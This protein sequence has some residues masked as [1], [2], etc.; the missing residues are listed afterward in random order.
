MRQFKRIFTFIPILF[1]ILQLSAQ[2]SDRIALELYEGT[3]SILLVWDLPEN[4]DPVEIIIL[5]KTEFQSPFLKLDTVTPTSTRYCD[6][7]IKQDQR[8]FYK[9][10]ILLENGN[11][12]ESQDDTPPFGRSIQQ[13]VSEEKLEPY[14]E[15]IQTLSIEKFTD[16]TLQNILKDELPDLSISAIEDLSQLLHEEI[17]W[18]HPWIKVFLKTDISLLTP[19]T[20]TVFHQDIAEKFSQSCFE[21]QSAI[22]NRMMITPTEWK[23]IQGKILNKFTERFRE[24]SDKFQLETEYYQ[25]LPPMWMSGYHPNDKHQVKILLIKT[26]HLE[27]NNFFLSWEN[28]HLSIPIEKSLEKGDTILLTIPDYWEYANLISSDRVIQTIPTNSDKTYSIT[29][30]GEFICDSEDQLCT[31]K[32][33]AW[34]NE[35]YVTPTENTWSIEIAGYE[36]LQRT[37]GVFNE[38]ELI[39]EIQPSYLINEVFYDSTFTFDVIKEQITWIHLKEQLENDDW[40]ILESKMLDKIEGSSEERNPDGGKWTKSQNTTLGESNLLKEDSLAPFIPAIFA[41]YQNYPNPFNHSTTIFFDMI[42]SAVVNLHISDATGRIIE[43]LVE[44][45]LLSKG[46]YNF[47]W[48]GL[49]LSSGVYFITISAQ[50][51]DYPPVVFSRKMIYLK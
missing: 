26:E 40:R 39:W 34:I 42:E 51:K 41:L 38:E 18:D 33:T 3:H 25:S 22:R 20:N 1:L 9:M 12:I 6:D 48:E 19:V 13:T 32:E 24:L 44:D 29:F 47:N 17:R 30:D 50:T 16:L 21:V 10:Q 5:R 8:Y 14:A 43:I 15:Y 37:Y 2:N 31:L 7:Q 11:L 36:D 49:Q 4:T 35:W 28:E 27:I 23:A 45:E 46:S